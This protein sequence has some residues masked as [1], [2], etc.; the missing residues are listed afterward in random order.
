M[1]VVRDWQDLRGE[2]KAAEE[3]SERRTRE[4]QL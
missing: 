3:T 2:H 1:R 4:Q